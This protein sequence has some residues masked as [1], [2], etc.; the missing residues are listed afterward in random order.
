MTNC[1]DNTKSRDLIVKQFM[2]KLIKDEISTIPLYYNIFEYSATQPDSMRIIDKL[3]IY[4]SYQL[5]G[6]NH[7]VGTIM[8]LFFIFHDLLEWVF[9]GK[10]TK[11]MA[12]A[13]FNVLFVGYKS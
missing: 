1:S 11:N 12:I 4:F 7:C 13:S 9:L 2:S 10:Y 3:I 5:N 8:Y 6:W